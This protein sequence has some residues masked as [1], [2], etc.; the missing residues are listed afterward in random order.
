MND[1]AQ[2]RAQRAIELVAREG[3]DTLDLH[4]LEL[5]VLPPLTSELRTLRRLDLSGN[6]LRTLPPEIWLRSRH[7]GEYLR[8]RRAYPRSRARL[9]AGRN[10]RAKRGHA[11][12]IV[13]GG[14]SRA[15]NP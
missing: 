11:D 8:I 9:S 3:L 12:A 6:R 5:K 4:G 15:R 1:S 2:A 10:S 14:A 7:G 13:E